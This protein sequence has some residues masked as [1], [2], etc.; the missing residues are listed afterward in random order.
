[1]NSW[2]AIH[3]PA[4]GARGVFP[5][6][7][8]VPSDAR[9]AAGAP[10]LAVEMRASGHA[11]GARGVANPEGVFEVAKTNVA[12]HNEEDPGHAFSEWMRKIGWLP[13]RPVGLVGVPRLPSWACTGPPT[14]AHMG[15]PTQV[16]LAAPR[17]SH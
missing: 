8:Q 15:C 4:A 2:T 14:F 3:F 13:P 12:T 9:A 6:T 1:M 17:A 11:G 10:M 7:R 5:D 16:G